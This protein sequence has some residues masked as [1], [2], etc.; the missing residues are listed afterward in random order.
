MIICGKG[1]WNHKEY[2]VGLSYDYFFCI[3]VY[4]I[5]EII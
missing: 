4:E 3:A 1:E 5:E 2:A